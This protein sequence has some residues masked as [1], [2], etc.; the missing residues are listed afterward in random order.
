V[1]FGLAFSLLLIALYPQRRSLVP[2][3]PGGKHPPAA[4]PDKK[5]EPLP[6]AAAKPA[7]DTS[8]KNGEQEIDSDPAEKKS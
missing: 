7:G 5:G 6:A 3:T 8:G 1:F 4:L 2:A